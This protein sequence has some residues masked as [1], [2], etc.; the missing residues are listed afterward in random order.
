MRTVTFLFTDIVDS[1]RLWDQHP[2][3]MRDAMARHDHL[4]ET[5]VHAA[6][7]QLVRPRGEGDSRFAVF[8]EPAGA[9]AAALRIQQALH[10]ELWTLPERLR[11]RIA[12]HT[13]RAEQREDDYYGTDVN[14]C[15]RLRSLAHAGQTLLSQETANLAGESLPPEACLR[16]LG[17]HTLK[18][19]SKPEHIFQLCAPDIA[20]DFPPLGV[21]A[22]D[23]ASARRTLI[24]HAVRSV[25]APYSLATRA[26]RWMPRVVLVVTVL[27]L[28]TVALAWWV[29]ARH[30]SPAFH[31]LA[32]SNEGVIITGVWPGG[33]ADKAGL[34]AGDVILAID[35]VPTTYW[36]A[37]GRVVYHEPWVTGGTTTMSILAGD[38]SGVRSV[39]VGLRS[40]IE[41]Q[42]TLRILITATLVGACFAILG[43]FV[44]LARPEDAAARLLL[45]YSFAVAIGLSSAM[46]AL[47]G[48]QPLAGV[49]HYSVAAMA[50][51]V[52]LNL[53][54][55][56]P[57]RHSRL[58]WMF[59]GGWHGIIGPRTLLYVLV[60][61]GAG[62]AGSRPAL[63]AWEYAFD[64]VLI[65]FAFVV[66][67]SGYRSPLPPLERAQLTWIALGI[68]ITLL[69]LVVAIALPPLV[70]MYNAVLPP[71]EFG[72]A[73]FVAGPLCMGLAILR[74]RLFDVDRAVRLAVSWSLIGSVL[75]AV[76]VTL[77]V[78][79]SRTASALLGPAVGSDPTLSV[80]AG[81]LVAGVAHPFRQRAQ[82]AIDRLLFQPHL[83]SFQ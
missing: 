28:V 25:L 17:R 21:D 31:E 10:S 59:D 70:D 43:A 37:L 34:H 45:V 8:E 83:K 27:Y 51:L 29:T 79:A 12:V 41:D 20:N 6:G 72:A 2:A 38:G 3:E 32:P 56:F 42:W 73:L 76:Y 35:G 9:V 7:G 61:G 39:S 78:L 68:G 65:L 77:A 74:Y 62:V 36:E 18:G 23:L 15:A 46:I 48:Q 53:S 24:G 57:I 30:G 49:A 13:G 26:H 4:I 47:N 1:T 50:S 67:L 58:T 60:I 44:A 16:S 71:S 55:R 22:G 52:F 69:G 75:L 81:L 11:V 64:G 33:P 63:E 14:R 82:A 19:L 40:D 80:L 5:L 54:V 66:V